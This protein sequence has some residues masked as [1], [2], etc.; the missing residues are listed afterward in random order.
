MIDSS[1]ARLLL[2]WKLPTYR[3]SEQAAGCV[4]PVSTQPARDRDVRSAPRLYTCILRL[5]LLKVLFIHSAH[6]RVPCSPLIYI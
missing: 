5:M 1:G 3:P 2:S 6:F 4:A